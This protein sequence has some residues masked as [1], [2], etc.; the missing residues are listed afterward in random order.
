[1][2]ML[3]LAGLVACAGSGRLEDPHPTGSEVPANPIPAAPIPPPPAAKPAVAVAVKTCVNDGKPFDEAVMKERLTFLASKELD[4]RAPGS[5]GD[6]A[7][8]KLIVERFRCLGLVG[9]GRDGAFELPFEHGGK[10]TA[11]IVGYVKGGDADVGDE[12]I[13][14]GAH[15]DHMGGGYLGANDNASGVV[16]LL[17]I[18]QAVMQR[19]TKPKRTIVFATFGAEE[20]GMVGSYHLAKNPPKGLPNE[21]VV[22]FVNL[23]MIGSHASK[24]GVAAM[25]AFPRLASRAFLEKLDDKFPKLTVWIGGRARGSDYEPL[26]KL[27]VPYVFFWTPDAKCYHQKCDTADRIDYPR[28]VDIA[29]LAGGLVDQMADTDKDL[30]AARKKF[31]CGV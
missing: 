26:C 7:A 22:Q 19:P 3:L 15:H 31:G 18:A 21:K 1:M 6:R 30:G 9:T 25:G 4:G 8:R 23:D 5:D 20:E 17:A 28:M 27:G 14:V 29:A 16:G 12:I 10:A 24:R 2:R 11:N 13:Y